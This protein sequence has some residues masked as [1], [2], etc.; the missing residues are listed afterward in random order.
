MSEKVL[1]YI[2]RVRDSNG[3]IQSESYVDSFFMF[4]MLDGETQLSIKSACVIV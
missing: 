1:E 3:K 2:S 4:E